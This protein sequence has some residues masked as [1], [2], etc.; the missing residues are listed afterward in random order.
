MR[1]EAGPPAVRLDLTSDPAAAA[2]GLE[3]YW[4]AAPEA[5][6]AALRQDAGLL[7]A[8]A[9]L[10][11]G[12]EF[13]GE[14][15]IQNPDWL[16][17]LEQERRRGGTRPAEEWSA[18]LA[19]FTANLAPSERTRGLIR[20]KRREYL[21][22]ALR[23]LEGRAGLAETAGELSDLADAELQQAYGW[24]WNELAGEFGTPPAA[25][26]R[27]EFVVI[28]L[29]KLGGGELNYSSDIDLMFAY[30]GEGVT[31]GGR[32]SLSHH[33]FFTRLAQAIT[34]TVSAVTGEGPAYRVDLRLRPGGREG[35]L[36]QSWERLADYYLRQAREW[37]LQMLLR[38][39]GCA[40]STGLAARLLQAVTPRM[41]PARPQAAV[42]AE[43]VRGARLAIRQ[44]LLRHRA[45]G[46]RRSE[47]DVKLD[48][49]GIRDVEFLTQYLQRLHGGAEPW[50]RSGH[51]LQALQRLHDKGWIPS[52][53]L[54]LLSSAYILLRHVEHR[55]QLRW[56][57]QTH[58]LPARAAARQAL[59]LSLR[60][61]IPGWNAEGEA[62]VA[63]IAARMTEVEELYQR[64]LG[65]E[66]ER[67]REPETATGPAPW[68]THPR[69]PH[70]ERQASRLEQSLASR[71]EAAAALHSLQP[72]AAARVA[73]ALEHSDWMA[74]VLMRRPEL[75]LALQ[76]ESEPPMPEDMTELRLWQQGQ[77]LGLLSREWE[78][79]WPAGR[80]LRE[81]TT[82]AE[83][84]LV[85][86]LRLARGGGH[87]AP[88]L[89]LLGLGRLG[90]G[91]LD[92]LSDVDIVFVARD[93]DREDAARLAARWIQALTAYTQTGTLYAVDTRLRPGGRE[94]ELVQTPASMARYFREHAGWWEAVSYL[95][96]RA[97]AGDAA[98]AAEALAAV[99]AAVRERSRG[100]AIGGELRGL[101]DRMEREGKPGRWGLKTVA[102]G[103]YD[104]DFVIS[105]R[106]L[107]SGQEGLGP[108]GLAGWAQAAGR[109]LLPAEPAAELAASVRLL[110]AADH[111]LRVGTG[112]AGAA[113]PA[114]GAGLER[115][116]NWLARSGAVET[117]EVAAQAVERAQLR[118]REIY[119]ALL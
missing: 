87:A 92:L 68:L 93:E 24:A 115:G 84:I 38:A 99:Q 64:Y 31:R 74:E 14:A 8:L 105:R 90:L 79:R 19:A 50:V 9:A 78:Q 63:A 94:G 10:L 49:G 88:S 1:A 61:V 58:S 7:R 45:T 48:A 34:R 28:A 32:R 16:L 15:L 5:A 76:E 57:Q 72:A 46:R 97:V 42:L 20:F 80:S 110:R 117:A 108:I 43:G 60:A 18:L 86:C 77:L 96:A 3:R 101:R 59:A 95:K 44:Q 25:G 107:E 70:G 81:L 13:L 39:R 21:R 109:D 113:V 83:R 37:E 35:E 11:A 100:Q 56:G 85:H 30:S 55:L 66:Q 114:A 119:Q 17:W 2:A 75:A 106:L 52:H 22:I 4:V 67:V 47:V 69:S 62:A 53:D 54:Q 89:T 73:Q 98:T 36:A 111:A 29:G 91:E 103:Y 65:G 112:K 51:T 27:A 71:P 23:D 6:R 12:S 41:F 33:E 104:V 26:G 116:W 82:L 40:G 118:I 102:G